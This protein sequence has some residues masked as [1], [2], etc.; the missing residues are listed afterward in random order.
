MGIL[1][2]ELESNTSIYLSSLNMKAT[3]TL[4]TIF[5]TIGMM[6]LI[7]AH[8]HPLE[9]TTWLDPSQGFKPKSP[10]YGPMDYPSATSTFGKRFSMQLSGL[11]R[12]VD[13]IDNDAVLT[14][15]LIKSM[16]CYRSK[17]GLQKVHP[18]ICNQ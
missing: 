2:Q 9:D 4:C 6:L 13:S 5:V 10:F 11:N 7:H 18:S 1:T 15:N 3:L 14:D 8:G 16:L 12:L 17:Q